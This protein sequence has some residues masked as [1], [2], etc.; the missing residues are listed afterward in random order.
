MTTFFDVAIKSQ[1]GI[2]RHIC[3]DGIWTMYGSSKIK[4][5]FHT[6]LEDQPSLAKSSISGR[7]IIMIVNMQLILVTLTSES[8]YA[9]ELDPTEE[10]NDALFSLDET[11]VIALT[12]HNS[13]AFFSTLPPKR[14]QEYDFYAPKIS[15]RFEIR[16][17][18]QS[19]QIFYQNDDEV[20]E[21]VFFKLPQTFKNPNPSLPMT[22]ESADQE[23][24][25]KLFQPI[26]YE[27]IIAAND[28]SDDMEVASTEQPRSIIELAN[29]VKEMGEGLPEK[30]QNL[31]ERRKVI[32]EKIKL[33]KIQ[34]DELQ[35]RTNVASNNF[36]ALF[37]RIQNLIDHKDTGRKI[38]R[39]NSL[40]TSKMTELKKIT[41]SEHIV[42]NSLIL[43][44]LQY[45]FNE[46]IDNLDS[47]IQQN[48]ESLEE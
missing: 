37:G 48:I 36:C 21:S 16:E 9:D 47:I 29:R 34:G 30:Q 2:E 33:L 27:P 39:I 24:A 7:F 22:L 18:L 41:P 35:E 43:K 45:H 14:I 13:L 25:L 6:L 12:N 40:Y 46:R 23:E 38:P 8:L 31:I 17:T 4:H 32:E 19:I 28:E 44:F 20:E 5:P 15:Y 3:N 11:K 26:S 42:D 10:F 1:T